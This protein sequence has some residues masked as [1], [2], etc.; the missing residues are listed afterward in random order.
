MCCIFLLHHEVVKNCVVF[1]LL[2]H[3]VVFFFD[4]IMKQRRWDGRRG[5]E[6]REMRERGGWRGEGGGVLHDVVKKQFFTTS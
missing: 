5:T 6:D 1:L 2:H 3:E 4:Y